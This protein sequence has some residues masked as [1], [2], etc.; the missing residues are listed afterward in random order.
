MVLGGCAATME[1]HAEYGERCIALGMKPTDECKH[2]LWQ[3][4]RMARMV[5]FS[6][7]NAMRPK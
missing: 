7:W 5:G 1:M 2:H 4:D 3:Q 6:A